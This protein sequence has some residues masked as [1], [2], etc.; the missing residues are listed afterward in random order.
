MEF[1]FIPQFTDRQETEERAGGDM[2]QDPPTQTWC[3]SYCLVEYTLLGKKKLLWENKK[4]VEQNL[5]YTC[6][7][8]SVS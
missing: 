8:S 3:V 1:A 4:A 5:T 6:G 7:E 2:K